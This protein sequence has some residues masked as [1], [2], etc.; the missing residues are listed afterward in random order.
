[1]YLG[2]Y[3]GVLLPAGVYRSSNGVTDSLWDALTG[4]NISWTYL[5]NV[6]SDLSNDIK[7]PQ[8]LQQRY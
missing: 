3:I 4:R 1:M 6:A 8:I 7:S 2:A 5:E